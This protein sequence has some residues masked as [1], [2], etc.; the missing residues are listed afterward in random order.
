MELNI[1]NLKQLNV[2]CYNLSYDKFKEIFEKM[3]EIELSD[4]YVI[5]KYQDFR[6]KQ[7]G[8]LNCLSDNYAEVFL[9][10]LLKLIK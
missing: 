1:N 6:N 2:I 4:D 5:E 3:L 10:E 8:Y 9:N 7:L